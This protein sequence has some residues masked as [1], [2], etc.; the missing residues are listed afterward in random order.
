M[1]IQGQL[2]VHALNDGFTALDSVA[3][4][5]QNGR[6]L[7]LGA[8]HS[9]HSVHKTERQQPGSLI[10]PEPA[11]ATGRSS[12]VQFSTRTVGLLDG[13]PSIIPA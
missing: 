1:P 13:V 10:D 7:P 4:M 6:F 11:V 12:E 9:G 3:A 2:N 5:S 8:L